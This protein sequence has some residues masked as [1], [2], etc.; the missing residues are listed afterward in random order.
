MKRMISC[1]ATLLFGVAALYFIV[2]PA[3]NARTMRNVLALQDAPLKKE[4]PKQVVLDK[5]SQSDKYGEV[6]FNHETHSTKNYT[7]DGKGTIA[8]TVCHHTD[9][10]AAGLKPPLKTS[11]RKV[12]L[13]LEALKAPDA[14]GVKTCRACHLQSGDDSKEIPSVTYE[15]KPAATKLNNE[16]AYHLNC[17][18]CH[19]AAIKT[20]PD[21]KAK[22][23]GTND[24][25]KCHKPV[26]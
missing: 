8:C 22:I 3:G 25:T 1:I 12:A 11:E 5:D 9:Q 26:E 19:D 14:L 16:I 6:A 15:G 21:L 2:L 20:R 23:P 13:T 24:C 7:V 4:L 10:P 18:T 17:N